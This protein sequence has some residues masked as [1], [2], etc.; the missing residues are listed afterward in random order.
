MERL[1]VY[2]EEYIADTETPIT[3]YKKYVGDDIGFLLESKDKD[4]GRYSFIS[5]N[6]YGNLKF[7]NGKIIHNDKEIDSGI[8]FMD[9]LEGELDK[10]DVINEKKLPFAGGA[11]GSIAYDIIR[12]FEY[13][14]NVNPDELDLPDSELFFVREGIIIDHFHEKI[15]FIV[16]DKEENEEA[17]KQRLEEIKAS[18]YS[19]EMAFTRAQKVEGK[20]K[21]QSNTTKEEYMEMVKKAQEYIYEGDI[22]Q[23]V[24]SQRWK[25]ESDLDPFEVYRVL[26]SI[27]PSPYL[28]Y[29]NFG[30]Y[31]VA[32]SSPEMLVEL[33]DN[34]I[35]NC[36]IAGTRK[37]G[38][39]EKEDKLLAQEMLDDPKE[40]AEHVMLVDLARNDMGRIAEVG[41]VNV[42]DFMTVQ[43][44]SHVMH[45]VSL[46]EG[47]KRKD[48]TPFEVLGSFLPAGT[49][50]GA[51]KIRAM[52]IIDELEKVKRGI[53]GG[54]VGYFSYDG[55]MDT[56]IAIRT[57]VIKDSN[58]YMQAGAGIT[59][60]S[61]PEMEHE[62]CQNKIR[63]LVEALG[64]TL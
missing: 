31:K 30:E 44:Y 58:I 38:K 12:E 5:K 48:K 7:K 28:F 16:L 2:S 27:N 26:R 63:V 60:K 8:S 46:V 35:S 39:D 9:Y 13:L 4:K 23:V 19:K 36:P 57:M 33:T 62:E 17:A 54:A 52:E 40:R 51:P 25:L 32:G 34:K 49:L 20:K 37:R 18:I 15:I 53:Y 61:V 29:F 1:R 42:K 45:I 11:F 59:H 56:C 47:Q 21:V 50:S 64:G 22:F 24:L 10:V 41:T 6:A 43:N 55:N 3:V 14:P